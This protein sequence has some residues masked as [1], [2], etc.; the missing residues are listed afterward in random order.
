[1]GERTPKSSRSAASER[2]TPRPPRPQAKPEAGPERLQTRSPRHRPRAVSAFHPPNFDLDGHDTRMDYY[3]GDGCWHYYS[4]ASLEGEDQDRHPLGAWKW[5][6]NRNSTDRE[7]PAQWENRKGA[8]VRRNPEGPNN[9]LTSP[10][11]A[12]NK[13][14]A[15]G[16]PRQPDHPPPL[17]AYKGKIPPPEHFKGRGKA[18]GASAGKA[19]GARPKGKKD[20]RAPLQAPPRPAAHGDDRGKGPARSRPAASEP[21]QRPPHDDDDWWTTGGDSAAAGRRG[22]GS[23]RG[24]GS[25]AGS[26]DAGQ[27]WVPKEKK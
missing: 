3:D 12:A 4:N 11:P 5:V 20:D 19:S 24:S 7:P 10:G 14:K 23:G 1:M 22:R 2:E 21:Y 18:A 9:R 8:V 6:P 13:G 16:G 15:R 17:E 26:R 25:A 27:R